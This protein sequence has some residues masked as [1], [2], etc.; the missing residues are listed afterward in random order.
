MN[1]KRVERFLRKTKVERYSHMGFGVCTR[2]KRVVNEELDNVPLTLRT[3]VVHSQAVSGLSDELR[4]EVRSHR[5]Q[6]LHRGDLVARRAVVTAEGQVTLTGKHK[7]WSSEVG[8][9]CGDGAQTEETTERDGVATSV[10]N[11]ESSLGVVGWPE[12]VLHNRGVGTS[13]KPDAR[14]RGKGAG[15][16]TGSRLKAGTEEEL[17]DAGRGGRVSGEDGT[18]E[19]LRSHSSESLDLNGP[20]GVSNSNNLVEGSAVDESS[21][22]SSL[23]DS[24]QDGDLSSSLRLVETVGRGAA[25]ASTQAVIDE[26][27]ITGRG[28][29]LHERVLGR[30]GKVPVLRVE[31]NTVDS[32]DQGRVVL[33]ASNGRAV[34]GVDRVAVG[35]VVSAVD[36]LLH[37]VLLVVGV[38]KNLTGHVGLVAVLLA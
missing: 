12:E 31:A 30:V 14:L 33:L 17:N 1:Q 25:T 32:S 9:V 15:Q 29:L 18:I 34:S 7:D 4:G 23:E 8:S 5:V 22:A 16:G 10:R 24:G 20:V 11:V 21:V 3:S 37:V 35:I 26:D 6:V 36:I 27:V 13:G 38:T 19:E 2:S 28:S